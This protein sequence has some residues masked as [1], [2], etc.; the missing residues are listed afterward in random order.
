[1]MARLLPAQPTNKHWKEAKKYIVRAGRA[2]PGILE[3]MQARPEQEAIF[4]KIRHLE[5]NAAGVLNHE[6]PLLNYSMQ[7]FGVKLTIALF[8]EHT[9]RIIS[10]EDAISVR[11][12]TNADAIQGKL[13]DEALSIMGEQA[14]LEQG[15]WSVPNQF[16]YQYAIDDGEVPAAFFSAFR[17]SF[18]ILG[19]VW[20]DNSNVPSGKGLPTY[21][22]S[23]EGGYIMIQ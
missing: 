17:R 15:K 20:G 2:V 11:V 13:P 21:S 7:L 3:E 12:Y 8:Y 16:W 9:R 1:M 19:L 14:T 22:P 6:G 10:P 4:A 18:A 23:S 5:P